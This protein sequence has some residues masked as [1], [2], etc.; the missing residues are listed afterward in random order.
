MSFECCK[1]FLEVLF[2]KENL[3]EYNWNNLE[4]TK[5]NWY[6]KL[7]E[8]SI[9]RVICGRK[10]YC[11]IK[12]SKYD[13]CRKYFIDFKIKFGSIITTEDFESLMLLMIT[14]IKDENIL[15]HQL[16]I[17]SIRKSKE[18]NRIKIAEQI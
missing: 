7:V 17:V 9:P 3:K 18:A 11:S 4:L 2:N 6:R 15:W 13:Y 12:Q 10:S 16:Q 14:N 5:N 8:R 1:C